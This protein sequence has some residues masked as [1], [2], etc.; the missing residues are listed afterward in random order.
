MTPTKQLWDN[1]IVIKIE[2]EVKIDR[3][4][5]EVFAFIPNFEKNGDSHY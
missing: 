1:G 4:A 5:D 2:T 3:P